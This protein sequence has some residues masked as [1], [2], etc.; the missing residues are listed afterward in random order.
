MWDPIARRE[1][2]LVADCAQGVRFPGLGAPC[3]TAA[4]A[5]VSSAVLK[6]VDHLCEFV[7]TVSRSLRAPRH[8]RQGTVK[9]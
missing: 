1:L 4:L 7:W 8:T 9:F 6:S 5:T 3:G 2:L